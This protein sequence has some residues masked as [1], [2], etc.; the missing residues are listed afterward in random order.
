[1]FQPK[2]KLRFTQW[3]IETGRVNSGWLSI[4]LAAALTC[5]AFC[6]QSS[7]FE[8]LFYLH[9]IFVFKWIISFSKWYMY[10]IMSTKQNL[11][12]YVTFSQNCCFVAN[13]VDKGLVDDSTTDCYFI[14][15]RKGAVYRRKWPE[16]HIAPPPK[17]QF[18]GQ[19]IHTAILLCDLRDASLHGKHLRTI[20]WIAQFKLR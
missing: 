19:G 2:S 12:R 10:I 11:C 14:S 4:K 5:S 8:G 15:I 20:I 7:L 16:G 6:K 3:I 13:F 1:M 18:R 17:S 9:C